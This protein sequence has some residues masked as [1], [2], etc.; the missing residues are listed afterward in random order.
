MKKEKEDMFM[1]VYPTGTV[2]FLG[3]EF[4][5]RKQIPTQIAKPDGKKRKKRTTDVVR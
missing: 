2:M 5:A 3:E 4:Y 1:A